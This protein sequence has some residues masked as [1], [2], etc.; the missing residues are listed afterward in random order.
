LVHGSGVVP[1]LD[2]Y[3][4]GR[5]EK[6]PPPFVP[7]QPVA[8]RPCVWRCGQRNSPAGRA[9]SFRAR[10]YPKPLSAII[11]IVEADRAFLFGGVG[12][13]DVEGDVARPGSGPRLLVLDDLL[14]LLKG[15]V[16]R[17]FHIH[18]AHVADLPFCSA[19]TGG[20]L[21]Q[22]RLNRLPVTGE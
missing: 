16:L 3:L 10:P 9:R 6:L 19:M 4:K 1:T 12:L 2:E 18:L 22:S 11:V 7:R 14:V 15:V 5:V 20:Q 17:C 13:V 21:A 8:A